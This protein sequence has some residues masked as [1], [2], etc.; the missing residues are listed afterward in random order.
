VTPI[1][2]RGG[3]LVDKR[4]GGWRLTWDAS[5]QLEASANY[6]FWGPSGR[7]DPQQV[8]VFLDLA[9]TSPTPGWWWS[10]G[11]IE[12]AL[13][14]VSSRAAQRSPAA[15]T[16]T[17]AQAEALRDMV[18]SIRPP[19][20]LFNARG[21]PSLFSGE[22]LL[23]A[24]LRPDGAV[25]VGAPGGRLWITRDGRRDSLS[26]ESRAAAA[27]AAPP[28]PARLGG[29]PT[30]ATLLLLVSIGSALLGWRMAGA[31]RYRPGGAGPNPDAI[32]RLIRLHRLVSRVAV[33]A[34]LWF[35]VALLALE[36]PARGWAQDPAVVI[37]IVLACGWGIWAGFRAPEVLAP[38]RYTNGS[39]PAIPLAPD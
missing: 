30:A 18:R 14:A 13:K 22:I 3:V 2:K 7:R 9:W 19:S 25:E 5:G 16:L 23:D 36:P 37:P 1:P 39:V 24:E 17:V 12:R 34:V 26:P 8:A 33:I 4:V 20:R 29:S 27:Q 32:A 38:P 28:P 6:S 21:D 15:P 11:A 10:Y 35:V 31:T